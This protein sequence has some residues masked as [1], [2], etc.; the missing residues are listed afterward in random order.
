MR[1]PVGELYL[2]TA[3]GG[4][5]PSVFEDFTNHDIQGMGKL[6]QIWEPAAIE[7]VNSSAT[8]RKICFFMKCNSLEF[9]PVSQSP[10]FLI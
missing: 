4:I 1:I 9:G 5:R 8:D 6:R 10:I 3:L 2:Y 7:G